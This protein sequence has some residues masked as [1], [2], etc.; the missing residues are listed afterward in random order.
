MPSPRR[1]TQRGKLYAAERVCQ[2]P[3]PEFRT[4]I[5]CQVFVDEV[6]AEHREWFWPKYVCVQ[7]GRGRR[8]ACASFDTISVPRWARTRIVILHELAHI[9]TPP[10]FA[11]HGPEF[12]LNFLKLVRSVLGFD[13]Y[14]KLATSFEDHSVRWA[15][16]HIVAG[17]PW[18]AHKEII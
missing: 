1:D 13:Q 7:D 2:P 17:G 5:D 15:T 9:I 18:Q 11:W 8:S 16:K 14:N 3:E 12:A 10:P 4:V 6:I